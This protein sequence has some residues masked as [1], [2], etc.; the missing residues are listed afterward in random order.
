LQHIFRA[1][2]DELSKGQIQRPATREVAGRL[3]QV[4]LTRPAGAIQVNYGLTL[5][6]DLLLQRQHQWL[7]CGSGQEIF[8]GRVIAQLYFQCQLVLARV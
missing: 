3:Q 7:H 8:Q 2:F 5:R 4:G 6:C 1:I